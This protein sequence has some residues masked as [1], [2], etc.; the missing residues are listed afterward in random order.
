MTSMYKAPQVNLLNPN[1]VVLCKNMYKMPNI[2]SFKTSQKPTMS[3]MYKAPQVNLLNPKEVV[4]CKNM[5][6]MPNTMSF[7]TS[8]GQSKEEDL[9]CKQ[10]QLISMI[11][12]FLLE[13]SSNSKQAPKKSEV[14]KST[15]TEKAAVKSSVGCNSNFLKQFKTFRATKPCELT[16]VVIWADT[17][18]PPLSLNFIKTLLDAQFKVLWKVHKH[19]TL[20]LNGR[21]NADE[22]NLVWR[23]DPSVDRCEYDFV[24]TLVWKSTAEPQLWLS[25]SCPP[26]SGEAD[27]L[28][29]FGRVLGI[30]DVTNDLQTTTKIDS[31]LS[32]L[33]SNPVSRASCKTSP[34]AGLEGFVTGLVAGKTG[35]K[36]GDQCTIADAYAVS[37]AAKSSMI[38]QKPKMFNWF[39][40][41]GF[42]AN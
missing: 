38:F 30:Y 16:D 9:K 26:V 31:V 27:I 7:K 35:W 4:L 36:C 18:D 25:P 14:T 22:K 19:S 17:A 5:Y 11:D 12:Q 37:M 3:P 41:R 29:Y 42:L 33:E 32:Q 21:R 8:Q 1:D 20:D 15:K 10:E 39:A 24:V 2:M 28:R 13:K 6:K 23:N 34:D 40:S